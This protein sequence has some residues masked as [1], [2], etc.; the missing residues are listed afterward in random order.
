MLLCRSTYVVLQFVLL[1]FKR[2]RCTSQLC[3]LFLLL[4]LL[5][6]CLLA[7]F[8]AFKCQCFIFDSEKKA[9]QN[10]RVSSVS[11]VQLFH[12]LVFLLLVFVF[13]G[14]ILCS[15]L[16]LF[17]L[18]LWPKCHLYLFLV[19]FSRAPSLSLTLLTSWCSCWWPL[20]TK[21]KPRKTTM[22]TTTTITKPGK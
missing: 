18:L 5:F 11:F 10:I 22:T 16:V 12:F 13:V 20:Y 1:V 6:A 9:K 4:L 21:K 15:C 3:W 7:T 8:G 14:I 2:W 19:G 17:G